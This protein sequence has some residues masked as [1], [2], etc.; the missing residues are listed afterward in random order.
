MNKLINKSDLNQ[1]FGASGIA[2]DRFNAARELLIKFHA[3]EFLSVALVNDLRALRI[4]PEDESKP[5]LW[6]FLT[7]YVQTWA[8]WATYEILVGNHGLNIGPQGIFKFTDSSGVNQSISAV[9]R[10][11]LM[12]QASEYRERARLSLVQAF[13]AVSGTFNGVT[14]E[15][16]QVSYTR[17]S[18]GLHAVG[19]LNKSYPKNLL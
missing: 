15:L 16:P 7:N 13:Q 5:E 1:C 4:A 10:G 14:Y 11:N 17:S 3:P 2:E 19:S 6:V 18:I 8:A 12:K 9:E